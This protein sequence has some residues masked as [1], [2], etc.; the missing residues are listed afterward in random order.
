VRSLDDATAAIAELLARRHTRRSFIG[1]LGRLALAASG[2]GLIEALQLTAPSQAAFASHCSPGFHAG[3]PCANQS[4]C[5][6]NGLVTG[7][8]WL[9]CCHCCCGGCYTGLRY[10]KFLD[11]CH[12]CGGSGKSSR[13]YCGYPYCFNCKIQSCT[14]TICKPAWCS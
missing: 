2:A 1:R 11:C 4:S 12:T 8:Y 3:T 7:Q 6:A 10:V 14:T 13:V 9:S 5:S